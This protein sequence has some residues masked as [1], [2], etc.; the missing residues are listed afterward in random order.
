ML[1]MGQK[2]MFRNPL[3]GVLHLLVYAGFI[4]IN[5][6]VLEIVLDGLLGTHRLF[7]GF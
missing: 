6:E 7:A 3:V 5:I 2:K 4:I 1:A